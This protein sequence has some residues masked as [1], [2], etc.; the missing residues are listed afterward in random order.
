[1]IGPLATPRPQRT[2]VDSLNAGY[3]GFD[4]VTNQRGSTHTT[5]ALPA[6]SH[7][8]LGLVDQHRLRWRSGYGQW[9]GRCSVEHHIRIDRVFHCLLSHPKNT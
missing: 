8:M 5:A 6:D 9:V 4:G 7:R 1:M 3:I 2:P